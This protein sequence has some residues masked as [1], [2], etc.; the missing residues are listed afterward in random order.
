VP[1]VRLDRRFWFAGI[2]TI[3]AKRLFVELL[4]LRG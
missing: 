2:V 1:P 3:E 4:M